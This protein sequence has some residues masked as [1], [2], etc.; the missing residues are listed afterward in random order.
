MSEVQP[1]QDLN[2]GHVVVSRENKHSLSFDYEV[3]LYDL[4]SFL[5]DVFV[6]LDF[7]LADRGTHP[8][9]EALFFLIEELDVKELLLVDL[10]GQL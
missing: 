4:L 5:I 7:D 1:F 6:L 9:D 10:H 3:H 8:D 2:I